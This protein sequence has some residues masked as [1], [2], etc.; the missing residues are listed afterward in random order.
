MEVIKQNTMISTILNFFAQ[1]N[2]RGV[3]LTIFGTILGY[4]PSAANIT[5]LPISNADML[6]QRCVWGGT[7]IVAIFAIIA[8]IQKQIDRYRTKHPKK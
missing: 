3:F 4:V 5:N 2:L 7:I 1:N 6:F 8:G